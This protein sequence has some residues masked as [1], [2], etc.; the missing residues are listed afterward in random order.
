MYNA[1]KCILIFYKAVKLSNSYSSEILIKHFSDSQK[2][3]TNFKSTLGRNK[4]KNIILGIQIYHL[5]L[6]DFFI[7]FIL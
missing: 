4:K 1:F 7:Y 5:I 3:S 2:L 6:C